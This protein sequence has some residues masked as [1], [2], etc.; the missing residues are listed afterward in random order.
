PPAPVADPLTHDGGLRIKKTPSQRSAIASTNETT[1]EPPPPHLSGAE[2]GLIQELEEA[3]YRVGSCLGHGGMATVYLAVQKSLERQ[4]ALKV[5]HQRESAERTR[6]AERFL[7]EA[8][9]AARVSHP[10]VATIYDVGHT[11]SS[12]YMAM[13]Y[14]SGGDLE[15]QLRRVERFHPLEALHCLCDILRGLSA[16]HDHGLIHRDIKTANCFIAKDSRI[17]IGDLGIARD[18]DDHNHLTNPRSVVGTPA[19]MAPEQTKPGAQLDGR[20]DIYAAGM[21][22]FHCICG[23]VPFDG[24]NSLTILRQVI[25]N[26]TPDIRDYHH[27][28]DPRIA[29][30]LLRL[31]ARDP[32]Q[33]PA[34]AL[35][36]LEAVQEV[37][38]LLKPST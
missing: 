16:L 35:E 13:E 17:T 3:G 22:A 23:K 34:N 26:P 5:H 1:N 6:F 9:M 20:C 7:Q 37:I 12:V 2:P 29:A 25:D 21:V 14:M 10:N 19:F 32:H 11:P 38:A 33:R 27:K 15:Q 8:R 36:A 28:T 4:V 18:I 24:E 31:M 30:L